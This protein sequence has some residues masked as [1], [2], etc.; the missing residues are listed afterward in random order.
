MTLKEAFLVLYGI[1]RDKD[2]LVATHMVL[3]SSPLQWYVGF[4]W[5]AHDWEVD[6]LT[7]FFTLLYSIRVRSER[8][9]TKGSLWLVLSIRFFLAKRKILSPGEVFGGPRFPLK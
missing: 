9:R 8:G 2:T 6:V 5:A 7:Y 3:E 1:A 4:I